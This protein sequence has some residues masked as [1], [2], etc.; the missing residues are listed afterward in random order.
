MEETGDDEDKENNPKFE[1]YNEF[2]SRS[3][4]LFSLFNL[5]LLVYIVSSKGGG[6]SQ[7]KQEEQLD[8]SD[9]QV[10]SNLSSYPL[11][12]RFPLNNHRY[13]GGGHHHGLQQQQRH[14]YRNASNQQMMMM[15]IQSNEAERSLS[16][17]IGRDRNGNNISGIA[18]HRDAHLSSITSGGDNTVNQ[19]Y[20]H[21]DAIT[22]D[23]ENIT[24]DM[25]SLTGSYYPGLEQTMKIQLGDHQALMEQIERNKK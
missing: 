13:P 22:D 20:H 5:Y 24:N 16:S 9:L 25:R 23:K 21:D 1:I 6:S 15:N 8:L 2:V 14:D 18:P 17:I 10:N 12:S 4:S 11:N 3:K 19:S 7:K